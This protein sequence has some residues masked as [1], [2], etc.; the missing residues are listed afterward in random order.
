MACCDGKVDLITIA[1]KMD[2][3]AADLIP[4]ALKLVD[5]GLIEELE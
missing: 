1:E 4:Y 2:V 3:Y 5:L